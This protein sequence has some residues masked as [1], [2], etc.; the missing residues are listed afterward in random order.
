MLEL[1]EL[2]ELDVL[3]ELVEVDELELEEVNVVD[4]LD[5]V[6]EV[7]DVEVDEDVVIVGSLKIHPSLLLLSNEFVAS[8]VAP[9]AALLS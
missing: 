3:V 2:V 9:P 6:E 1:V 7:L 8:H 5:E 4:V